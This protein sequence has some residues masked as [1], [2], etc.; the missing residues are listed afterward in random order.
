MTV[1]LLEL[2]AEPAGWSGFLTE[3]VEAQ[4][5]RARRLIGQTKAG[6]PRDTLQVLELWNRRAT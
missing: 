6:S 3:A 4:L 1:R 5:D 2:P